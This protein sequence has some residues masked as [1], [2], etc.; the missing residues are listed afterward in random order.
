[1]AAQ[2]EPI[3]ERSEGGG[4]RPMGDS[5]NDVAATKV[6]GRRWGSTKP[7]RVTVKAGYPTMEKERGKEEGKNQ[8]HP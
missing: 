4:H 7:K 5:S 1:L 3:S 2:N 8:D 6:Q